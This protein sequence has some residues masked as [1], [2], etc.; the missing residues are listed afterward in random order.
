MKK[1]V[2]AGLFLVVANACT[3]PP[4]QQE[5]G[6]AGQPERDHKAPIQTDSTEYYLRFEDSVVLAADMQI[7]FRNVTPDT[8]YIV[9]C[10]G[11][12]TPAMQQKTASGWEDFVLWPTNA[13]LSAPIVIPPNQELVDTFFI[14]GALPG[15][16]AGPAFPDTVLKGE[17]RIVLGGLVWHYD[18]KRM[19]FGER[20]PEQYRYSN[21]FYLH[22][23]Y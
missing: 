22:T 13:C 15:H 7:R 20:V 6:K 12:L 4:S 18:M 21:S 16:N 14:R 9:N 1:I 2:T 5:T 17:Y 3:N 23:P 19:D 8:I 11:A 10:N